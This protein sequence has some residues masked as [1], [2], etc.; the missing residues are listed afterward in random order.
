MQN[1]TSSN[2]PQTIDADFGASPGTCPPNNLETPILL[3]V[4]TTP[5]ARNNLVY[6]PQLFNKST[7]VLKATLSCLCLLDI[8]AAFDTIDHNIHVYPKDYL[9]GF[10]FTPTDAALLWIQSYPSSR[11]FSVKTSKASSQ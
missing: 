3:A 10:G 9:P 11:S 5:Y 2:H 6:L 8:S 4:T 7:P 1:K